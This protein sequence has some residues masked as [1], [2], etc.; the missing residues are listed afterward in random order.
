[1][2]YAMMMMERLQSM[3]L[4]D[5]LAS[6]LDAGGCVVGELRVWRV[7]GGWE[8]RHGADAEVDETELEAHTVPEAAREIARYDAAGVY[9]PLKSAPTL[10]RGWRLRVRDVASLRE[11]LDFVYPAALGNWIAFGAGRAAPVPLRQ[12]LARQT[13]MYKITS[14]LDDDGCR[15]VVAATC[16]FATRCRRRITWPL[17]PGVPMS[18]LPEE[19]VT[20]D[21][22]KDELPVLC[23]EACNVL[24][25]EARTYIKRQRAAS[26][27]AG[28]EKASAANAAAGQAASEAPP[29]SAPTAT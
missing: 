3:N 16:D 7:A 2:T 18:V 22:P 15:A 11:V 26:E 25:A 5:A 6:W 4:T 1:M 20:T 9:R 17:A 21:L 28:A 24:V 19:K 14:Q 23:L 29:A 13:G 10:V 8:V 27:R 12:T